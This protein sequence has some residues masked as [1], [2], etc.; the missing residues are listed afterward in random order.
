MKK[1]KQDKILM[2]LNSYV[3]EYCHVA[4]LLSP[5]YTPSKYNEQISKKDRFHDKNYFRGLKKK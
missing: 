5:C 3:I 1:N 4:E 2:S